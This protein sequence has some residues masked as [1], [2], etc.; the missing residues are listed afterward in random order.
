MNRIKLFSLVALLIVFLTGPVNIN[1]QSL[2]HSIPINN[3][4]AD[5]FTEKKALKIGLLI[6]GKEDL[7]AKN[8]A[9]LAIE[10]ANKNGR[11]FQL[12]IRST[13]GPWG[14]GSKESVNLVFE[15]EVLAFMGSLNGR[16]AHLAEQ[17]A[18]KTKIA[19]LSSQATDM[20]LSQAFVPWY[21]RCIPNDLQQA[22]SLIQEIYKVRQ[23][24][25][26]TCI[27]MDDYDSKNALGTFIKTLDS[28]N[29]P[30]PEQIML[31]SSNQNFKRILDDVE[32]S[33]IEAILIFGNSTFASNLISQMKQR[34]M[35]QTI[36]GTLSV[37]NNQKI[38][39]TDWNIFDEAI[40]VSP[41]Y[42]FTDEGIAF[43]KEFIKAYGYQANPIAAYAYD[44]INIIINAINKAGTDRDKII[45]ALAKTDY[46][47]GVTGKIQ[48]DKNGN[49]TGNTGLMIFR[50]GKPFI[51]GDNF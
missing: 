36:F 2:N 50:N 18:A 11:P 44:G 21:F 23:I 8:G 51:I 10:K 41:G 3:T 42:W 47:I 35:K 25:N 37:M 13:E 12:I 15:D 24:K 5:S 6:P 7:S 16:D 9:K 45:D 33:K 46:K 14:T 17:V 30:D 26:L 4:K 29:V 40:L 48:F 22:L 19:F 32:N 38:P 34:N 1:A 43:Q 20:T 39:G 49:R 27:A 28:F 31:K